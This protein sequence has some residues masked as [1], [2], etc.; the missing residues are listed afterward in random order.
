MGRGLPI[1]IYNMMGKWKMA[2]KKGPELKVVADFYDVPEAAIYMKVA[3]GT[4]YQR[5]HKSDENGIPV[6]YDG[7][8]PIFFIEELKAWMLRRTSSI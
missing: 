4:V 5:I 8:K 1:L 2:K 3:K 7:R 6:R